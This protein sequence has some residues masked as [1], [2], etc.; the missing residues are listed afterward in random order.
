MLGLNRIASLVP[1]LTLLTIPTSAHFIPNNPIQ[2]NTDTTHSHSQFPFPNN[3]TTP[4][5][6]HE[7]A[8]RGSIIPLTTREHWMRQTL[9]AL[10]ASGLPC[11]FYPFAAAVVN[12]TGS[13]N[14]G[15]GPGELICTGIN[16]G[17]QSGNMMLHGEVAAIINCTAILQDPQGRFRLSPAETIAAFAEFS[18][19]TNAESC[20]M[21]AS[22][23]RWNGFKEYIYGT[24]IDTLV[25]Y[26]FAQITISSEEIF[27]AAEGLPSSTSLLGGV[28]T[29]QTD[30]LFAWQ[31]DDAHPCPRGC[32]RAEEGSCTSV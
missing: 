26:G 3:L 31:F 5:T 28:L 30:A 25:E 23:I 22:A 19:Y 27:N 1:L 13:N 12:H 17:R 4:R 11:P 21:C 6:N 14:N 20:P 15:P 29:G 2:P 7:S 24:S 16:S 8:D 9:V 10:N 18:L 32:A